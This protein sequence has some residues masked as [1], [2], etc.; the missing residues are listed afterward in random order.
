LRRKRVYY[1]LQLLVLVVVV[2]VVVSNRQPPKHWFGD[3]PNSRVQWYPTTRGGTELKK[4]CDEYFLYI[5]KNVG[6]C[7]KREIPLVDEN[8]HHDKIRLWT[9]LYD[10]V[11]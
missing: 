11:V 4:S 9:L 6:K 8:I 1:I 3:N 7:V 10:C 2:V 5:L